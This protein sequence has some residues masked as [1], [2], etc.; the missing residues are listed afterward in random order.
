[1][2]TRKK[3]EK[4]LKNFFGSIF[5]NGDKLREA[6]IEYPIKVEYYKITNED[7]ILTKNKQMYGIQII[8]TEY[9]EKISV[10][11]SKIKNITNNEKEINKMLQQL[12]ECEV[13]PIGLEDV[14]IELEE[15]NNFIY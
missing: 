1:M 7:E 14:L 2:H 6:G 4:I 12:K 11:Q 9:K 5:I 10:E 8:K 15:K 13:T 3:G